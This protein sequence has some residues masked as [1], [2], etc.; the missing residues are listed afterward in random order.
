MCVSIYVWSGLCLGLSRGPRRGDVGHQNHNITFL[1]SSDARQK[2][3]FI[4][5]SLQLAEHSMFYFLSLILDI[6]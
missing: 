1:Q 3:P 5:S 4:S 2:H 6:V